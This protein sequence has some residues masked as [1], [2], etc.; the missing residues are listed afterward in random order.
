MTKKLSSAYDVPC[1]SP[2]P[3]VGGGNRMSLCGYELGTVSANIIWA[4]WITMLAQAAGEAKAG[5][6]P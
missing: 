4:G 6:S 2:F 1:H 3:D 5:G